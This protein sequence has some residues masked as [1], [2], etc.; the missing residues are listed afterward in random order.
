MS[1]KVS[2]EQRWLVEELLDTD[3]ELKVGFGLGRFVF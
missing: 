1:Y 3:I 2:K